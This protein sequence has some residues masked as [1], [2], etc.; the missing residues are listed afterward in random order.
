MKSLSILALMLLVSGCAS[1]E[2]DSKALCDG[3]RVARSEHA[4][5]LSESPHDPSVMTGAYLIQLID[6]GCR[7]NAN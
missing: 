1:V 7:D 3:T 6:A 2:S 5:T 4:Q